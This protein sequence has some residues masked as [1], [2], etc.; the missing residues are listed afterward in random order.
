MPPTA[1]AAAVAASPRPADLH[2]HP[3]RLLRLRSSRH[4]HR[5][6]RHR[7]RR[8]PPRLRH[9]GGSRARYAAGVASAIPAAILFAK[10]MMVIIGLTATA[11][12]KSEA[13]AT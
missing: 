5:P 10:A 7:T 13:S 9:R 12:G 1:S 4:L 11:V 3:R 6:R 2:L 8:R